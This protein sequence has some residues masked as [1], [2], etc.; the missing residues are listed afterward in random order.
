MNK[1]LEKKQRVKLLH[2]YKMHQDVYNA[3]DI[4]CQELT[5]M[6]L[7]DFMDV[8]NGLSIEITLPSQD[9]KDILETKLYNQQSN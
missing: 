5:D 9:D 3:L 4:K 6:D 8:Y 7:K 2:L 1:I